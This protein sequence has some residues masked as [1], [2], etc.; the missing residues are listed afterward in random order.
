MCYELRTLGASKPLKKKGFLFDI[1]KFKGFRSRRY[2]VEL[3]PIEDCHG[4]AAPIEDA[5]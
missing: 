3:V 5:V 4:T 2:W 1:I